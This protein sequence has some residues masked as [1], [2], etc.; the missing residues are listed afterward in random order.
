MPDE[1]FF[2]NDSRSLVKGQRR[3]RRT[4]TRRPA[5]FHKTNGESKTHHGVVLDLNAYGLRVRTVVRLPEGT[6]IEIYLRR[7]GLNS[8]L[9]KGLLGRVA[10]TERISNRQFDMGVELDVPAIELP[11]T[12]VLEIPMRRASRRRPASRMHVVDFVV[13]G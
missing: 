7:N 13:G 4:P 10:R 3:D 1:M 2:S 8:D 5:V 9:S 12:E 6:P 11:R